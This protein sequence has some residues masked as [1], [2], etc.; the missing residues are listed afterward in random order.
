MK[1]TFENAKSA[2][3]QAAVGNGRDGLYI[4]NDEHASLL[5]SLNQ[6]HALDASKVNA[7]SH[8]PM[9]MRNAFTTK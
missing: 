4:V 5:C 8:L 1:S 9:R 6:L 2:A 3:Q 7:C